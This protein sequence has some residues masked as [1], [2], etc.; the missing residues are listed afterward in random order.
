MVY[1]ETVTIICRVHATNDSMPIHSSGLNP[2][3]IYVYYVGVCMRIMPSARY[4]GKSM[5]NHVK[6]VDVEVIKV[7][8]LASEVH[9]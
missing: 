4:W 5:N 8:Q 9:N 2:H 6:G 7:I 1:S 3:P